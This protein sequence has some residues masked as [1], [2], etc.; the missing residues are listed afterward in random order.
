MD[1]FGQKLRALRTQRNL[2]LA[3]LATRLGYD[4]HSYLSEVESG[5]KTPS[6]ELVLKVSRTFGVSTDELLKDEL[7]VGGA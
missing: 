3:D 5:K 2:T 6:T 1:R 7:E 4:S